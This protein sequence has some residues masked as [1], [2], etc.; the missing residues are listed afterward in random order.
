M[1]FFMRSQG[2]DLYTFGQI[3]GIGISFSISWIT[4][5]YRTLPACV[6]NRFAELYTFA[7]S[8][9]GIGFAEDVDALV[10]RRDRTL[11]VIREIVG[12]NYRVHAAVNKFIKIIKNLNIFRQILLCT[13]DSCSVSFADRNDLY[14]IEILV[15]SAE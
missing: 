11:A 9:C 12:K 10:Q 1:L 8:R 6:F 2:F 15:S 3:F 4:P 5:I 7:E 13:F 14:I